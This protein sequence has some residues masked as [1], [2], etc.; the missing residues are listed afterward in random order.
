[1][2]PD[3]LA[4]ARTG[5]ALEAAWSDA[6]EEAADDHAAGPG[7]AGRLAVAGA[8][9]KASRLA[10]T[11]LATVSSFCDGGAIARRVERLLDEEAG[12]RRFADWLPLSVVTAGLFVAAA[13][14]LP[15][16]YAATEAIVRRLQ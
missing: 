6:A 15:L 2:A 1:L 3:L 13:P 14:A 7:R 9:L 12:T 11:R 8:L 5:R 4:W 16:V 10:P